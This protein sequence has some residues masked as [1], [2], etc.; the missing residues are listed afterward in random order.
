M[1]LGG[2]GDASLQSARLSK[3]GNTSTSKKTRAREDKED[4]DAGG[5][6]RDKDDAGRQ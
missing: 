5:R 1:D 6:M 2:P 3:A 4:R